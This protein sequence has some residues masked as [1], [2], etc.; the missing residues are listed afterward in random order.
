MDR[1]SAIRV[2]DLDYLHDAPVTA[3]TWRVPAD[4]ML[5]HIALSVTVPDDADGPFAGYRN[6]R[7]D[8]V[9]VD[10]AVVRFC[11]RGSIN[12]PETFDSG[13]PELLDDARADRDSLR[14]DGRYAGD[15]TVGM[16]FHSG[17]ELSVSCERIEL[18]SLE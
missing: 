15:V 11:G 13:G 3:L 9:F 12:G 17:S 14:A 4:G 10:A 2:E 18:V 16:A 8:V 1:R 7:V 5:R 6:R